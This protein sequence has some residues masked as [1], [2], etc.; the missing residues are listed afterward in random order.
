[1]EWKAQKKTTKQGMP[2][3]K[4]GTEEHLYIPKDT[5]CPKKWTIVNKNGHPVEINLNIQL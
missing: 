3:Y 5:Q 1:M 4:K 2:S